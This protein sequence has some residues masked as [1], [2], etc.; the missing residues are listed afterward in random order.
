MNLRM[1]GFHACCSFLAVIGKCF[2][3][4]GLKDL[5]IE[6]GLDLGDGTVEGKQ[7]NNATRIHHVTAEVLTRKKKN[8]CFYQMAD[9]KW[10][11]R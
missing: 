7:Y 11:Y 5:I 2:G 9:R 1:G 8:R 10:R 3:D 4:A 6:S